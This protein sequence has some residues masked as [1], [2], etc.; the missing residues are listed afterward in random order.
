[1][2]EEVRRI[3]RVAG[4][5]VEGTLETI[6]RLNSEIQEYADS[7]PG[8]DEERIREQTNEMMETYEI[9][10]LAWV[11]EEESDSDSEAESES[12]FEPHDEE[13]LENLDKILALERA[14]E[15]PDWKEWVQRVLGQATCH[16]WR[17]RSSMA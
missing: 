9:A 3:I 7:D 1:M 11:Q 16:T 12:E 6:V 8:A 14:E 5:G 13:L 4:E 15:G 17:W 10:M 2:P